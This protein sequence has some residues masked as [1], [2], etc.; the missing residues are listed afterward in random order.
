MPVI[1]IFLWPWKRYIF[2]IEKLKTI[3][4]EKEKNLIT[5]D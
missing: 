5:N 1:Y 4:K 2:I 3:E